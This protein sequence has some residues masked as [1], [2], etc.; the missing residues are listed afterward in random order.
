MPQRLFYAKQTIAFGPGL[1]TGPLGR[2]A[3]QSHPKH[4]TLG[5]FS[6]HRI[7]PEGLNSFP[8]PGFL[9]GHILRVLLFEK[10]ESTAEWLVFFGKHCGLGAPGNFSFMRLPW[11]AWSGDQ[12]QTGVISG[13]KVAYGNVLGHPP[14]AVE[15]SGAAVV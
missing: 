8:A 2:F 15:S 7:L 6:E 14:A 9:V 4:G 10:Q 11:G 5:V 12:A 3:G 13:S 1:Q